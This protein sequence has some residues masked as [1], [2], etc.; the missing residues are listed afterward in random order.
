MSLTSL[1]PVRDAFR[2]PLEWWKDHLDEYPTI[3]R[4]ALDF[5]SVPAMSTDCERVFNL[6]DSSHLPKTTTKR[7]HIGGTDL[8]KT[9]VGRQED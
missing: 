3:S 6:A 4:M 2:K 7:D 8:S 1:N 5:F 9:V